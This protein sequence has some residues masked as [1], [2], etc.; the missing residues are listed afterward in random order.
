MIAERPSPRGPPSLLEHTPTVTDPTDDR[1]AQNLLFK[2]VPQ[3]AADRFS[4]RLRLSE[5]PTDAVVF[6][7]GDEADGLYLVIEGGVRVSRSGPAG[8][9]V[10]LGYIEA[11]DFFGEIA[12]LDDQ[13]R[14]ARATTTCPTLLGY[15][16]SED[17]ADLIRLAPKE[18]AANLTRG[19]IRRVRSLN[20]R[21][22]D[23]VLRAERLSMI[24]QMAGSI[25]H[26]FKNPIGRVRQIAWTLEDQVATMSPEKM[27]GILRRASDE[28]LGMVEDILDY[29]RGT[30]RV[31]REPT[32]V[33]DLIGDLEEQLLGNLRRDGVEIRLDLAYTGELTVDRRALVRALVNIVKNA[34]EAMPGGGRLVIASARA[35]DAVVIAIED[36]GSGIPDHMLPKIFEAFETHGKPGGTGLG[37]A[38]TKAAIDAHGGSIDVSSRVGEGTTFTITLPLRPSTPP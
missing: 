3:A 28:M 31:S 13:P 25:V 8:R 21:Y 6:E 36:T 7:A 4:T 15:L 1:V 22:V 29:S 10:T 12:V 33:A 34:G 24:G 38:I 2:G 19:A 26:D 32:S 27:A 20:E 14:S 11:G 9:Q 17:V 18:M 5:A 23:E 30:L 35:G 37:M 16:P